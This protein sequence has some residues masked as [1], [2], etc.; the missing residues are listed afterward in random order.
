MKPCLV[1]AAK[2]SNILY[3]L[4]ICILLK[5]EN[6]VKKARWNAVY[7]RRCEKQWR[8][9]LYLLKSGE[10]LQA[11]CLGNHGMAVARAW[12][13]IKCQSR[14]GMNTKLHYGHFLV[15]HRELRFTQ[16]CL[17]CQWWFNL[18]STKQDALLHYERQWRC[19]DS[20]NGW[21]YREEWNYNACQTQTF[22][23]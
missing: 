16:Y 15:Y 7:S 9:Q 21:K 23:E 17:H 18:K 14:D 12:L 11:S 13:K 6:T 1:P 22:S 8:N 3:I 4:K 2:K 5:I 20:L 10:S 19:K